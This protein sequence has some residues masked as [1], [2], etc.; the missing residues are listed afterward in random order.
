MRRRAQI[1]AALAL[2][3]LCLA[4]PAALA[5]KPDEVLPDKALEA[6]AR[7]LSAQLRCLVCQNESI[8]ESDASFARDLRLMIRRELVAGW[9]DARIVDGLVHDYGQFILLR[10]RFEPAT[11][12]LWG[13]PA[14]VVAF[15]GLAVALR[16]RRSAPASSTDE[17]PLGAAEEAELR[18]LIDGAA[19][20]AGR[21]L[22]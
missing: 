16:A 9:S 1:A 5:V 20:P 19:A 17:A 11:W 22:T 4:A 7:A 8:D 14:L 18:R 6:R 2:A 21:E 12:A 10:P 13:A 15:A 3:A